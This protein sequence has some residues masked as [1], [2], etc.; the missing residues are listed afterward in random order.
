MTD[1]LGE[2]ILLR[3]RIAERERLHSEAEG[4]RELTETAQRQREKGNEHIVL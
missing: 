3:T 1:E 4:R 2:E